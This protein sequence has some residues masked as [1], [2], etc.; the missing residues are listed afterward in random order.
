[1]AKITNV[2]RETFN[3]MMHTTFMSRHFQIKQESS[4]QKVILCI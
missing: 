2:F 3:I 4:D 1:M